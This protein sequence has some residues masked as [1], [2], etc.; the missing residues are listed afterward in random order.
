MRKLLSAKVG[1]LPLALYAILF[2]LVFFAASIGRLPNDMIGGFAMIMV[3]GWILGEVGMRTP[4][5]RNIGGPAILSLFVP[6]ILIFHGLLSKP[7]LDAITAVMKTDNF[8]Y[9]YIACLVCGSVL[10]M[11][12]RILVQGF[13]RM[14]IPLLVGEIVTI[15]TG[16]GVGML[17]G[18]RPHH[19]FFYIIIP[20]IGGGIGEGILPY[21]LAM[22]EILA[23][24]QADFIPQLIPAAMLGNLFAIVS[25]GCMKRFGE[26]RPEFSGSGLLVRTGEDRELLAQAAHE[27]PVE[28]SLMGA[29]LLL[30]CCFFILGNTV[31]RYIGIPGPIIMIFS[32][33]LVKYSR[34][35]PE[36]ME[37]G[38]Y[39][40][41]RFIATNLTWPLLV[42]L[43]ALYV[44]WG[45]VVAAVTPAYV[46][47]CLSAVIAMWASGFV[48]GRLLGMYPVEAAIV[49]G[50]HT[51][52][53]GTG[54][55]AILSASNR[56][57][58]MPFAQAATRLGGA[59]M[60]VLATV[61]LKFWH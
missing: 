29:G 24:P 18:F 16:V 5:L 27:K 23:R 25:S 11:N 21:S 55:V 61:L 48:V 28:F 37:Q 58:L 32:A 36:K 35:M 6:S 13:L 10:G 20:I 49:T 9:L 57:G 46:V 2:A 54:D 4:V 34:L 3:L 53:G 43:G 8:L 1:P 7:A 19:T 17:F 40:M 41:Y 31:N 44:P 50:C 47:I 51:G 39:H 30:A 12:R 60:I 56:I 33:A 42:G 14:A 45:Q 38:A 52:L 26:K 15:A 59:L 22:A